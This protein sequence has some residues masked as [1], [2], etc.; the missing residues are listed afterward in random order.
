MPF[1]LLN[2]RKRGLLAF[3]VKAFQELYGG[4]FGIFSDFS[5]GIEAVFIANAEQGTK[6]KIR[7]DLS[8]IDLASVS[9]KL[10]EKVGKLYE[11]QVCK[12]R[13]CGKQ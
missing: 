1:M 3:N 2:L 7:S 9:G 5:D 12:E 11:G 4:A 10:G 8:L 6:R 13:F